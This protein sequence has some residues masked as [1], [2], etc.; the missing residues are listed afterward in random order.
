MHSE[1]KYNTINPQI[2]FQYQNKQNL[3]WLITEYHTPREYLDP[4]MQVKKRKWAQQK[5]GDK[6]NSYVTKKGFYMDYDLKIAKSIP[7][8]RISSKYFR[9]PRRTKTMGFLKDKK[10]KL[11]K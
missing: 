10:A 1:A 6:N 3:P 11:E 7:S 5:K 4:D 9:R 2:M 8:T